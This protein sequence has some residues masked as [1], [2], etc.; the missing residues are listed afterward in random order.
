MNSFG[1]LTEGVTLWR[2]HKIDPYS[3]VIFHETPLTLHL[4]AMIPPARVPSVFILID[5]MTAL[6]I[7]L[8]AREMVKYYVQ[9]QKDEEPG[10]H[11]DA[12]E[13]KVSEEELNKM[14]QRGRKIKISATSIS[15]A[16]TM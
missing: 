2:D 5:V 6:F 14:E 16:S 11:E 7:G 3:G 12:S 10:R 8:L 9:E 15:D 1:R 4:F 13:L